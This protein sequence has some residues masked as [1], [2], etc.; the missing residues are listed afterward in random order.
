MDLIS[1]CVSR[2][3]T[4]KTIPCRIVSYETP[5]KRCCM[6]IKHDFQRT[7]KPVS[8]FQLAYARNIGSVVQDIIAFHWHTHAY[9]RVVL[10]AFE[11]GGGRFNHFML[12]QA[13]R[14]CTSHPCPTDLRP[15]P[16]RPHSG[17]TWAEDGRNDGSTHARPVAMRNVKK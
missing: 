7:G 13:I 12:S 11:S 5:R 9:A 6:E 8:F 14:F 10:D 17:I 3:I 2:A 4:S 1:S 16:P 15:Y